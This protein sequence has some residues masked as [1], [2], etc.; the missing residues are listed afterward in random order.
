V[1][2]ANTKYRAVVTIGARDLAGNPLDQNGSAVGDQPK[3]WFFTTG[4]R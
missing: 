4:S 1:L 2:T 3:A